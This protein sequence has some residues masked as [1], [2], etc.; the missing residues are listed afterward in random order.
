MIND[1]FVGGRRGVWGWMGMGDDEVM[2]EM[3]LYFEV[4]RRVCVFFFWGGR[5]GD[6]GVL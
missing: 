4:V 1:L 6:D 5:G 3:L 2:S